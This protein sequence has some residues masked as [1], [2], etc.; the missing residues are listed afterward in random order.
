MDHDKIM[1]I[2]DK[3]I[4]KLLKWNQQEKA[5]KKWKMKKND[6]HFSNSKALEK[7]E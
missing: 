5:M 7:S 1:Y 6:F 2:D 3:L 4:E